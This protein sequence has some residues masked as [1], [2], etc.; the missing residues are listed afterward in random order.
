MFTSHPG[1]TFN[2]PILLTFTLQEHLSNVLLLSARN[3]MSENIQNT[4]RPNDTLVYLFDF[5]FESS[6]YITSEL[7]RK[8]SALYE[9]INHFFLGY[10]DSDND[11]Y[12]SLSYL[13]HFFTPVEFAVLLISYG[14]V[15]AEH[16]VEGDPFTYY[17]VDESTDYVIRLN[18]YLLPVNQAEVTFR[19]TI[20]FIPPVVSIVSELPSDQGQAVTYA[21]HHSTSFH[22]QSEVAA[23]GTDSD[24]SD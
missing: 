5:L 12:A 2:S 13:S 23:A 20:D 10:G 17:Q 22:A 18:P 16:G 3:K 9:R 1:T 14:L 24:E 7:E 15:R 6:I 4:A 11:V 8:A 19:E 21:P